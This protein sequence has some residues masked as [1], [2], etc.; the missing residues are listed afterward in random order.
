MRTG[1]WEVFFKTVLL[2][3]E[4]A[5]DTV[6]TQMAIGLNKGLK[7]QQSQMKEFSK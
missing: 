4:K 3:P 6:G 2:L 1:M 7:M 5:W